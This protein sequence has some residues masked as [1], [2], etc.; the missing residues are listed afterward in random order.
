MKLEK[1]ETKCDLCKGKKKILSRDNPHSY[2]YVGDSKITCSKCNGTGKLDF[3][4]KI[5]GKKSGKVKMR[6]VGVYHR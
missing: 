3:I 5:V 4:E 1:W 2:I 6:K